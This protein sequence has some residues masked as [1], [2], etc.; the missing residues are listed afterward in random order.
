MDVDLVI[1]IEW[2][3]LV[4]QYLLSEVEVEVEVVLQAVLTIFLSFSALRVLDTTQNSFAKTSTG[5]KITLE[6]ELNERI[7]SP[8]S[9]AFM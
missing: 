6:V 1:N 2:W 8:F 7:H 3:N 4:L 9:I 5:K